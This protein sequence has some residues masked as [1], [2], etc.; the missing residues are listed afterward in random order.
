MYMIRSLHPPLDHSG[1]R[2]HVVTANPAFA[3]S[4]KCAPFCPQLFSLCSFQAR[5]LRSRARTTIA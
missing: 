4:C 3:K 5:K 2:Y 1:Q